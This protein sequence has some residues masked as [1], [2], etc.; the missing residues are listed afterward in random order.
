M[1]EDIAELEQ[2]QRELSEKLDRK[3]AELEAARQRIIEENKQEL[4][5]L[6]YDAEQQIKKHEEAVL[7]EYSA[8]LER[9]ISEETEILCQEF[10]KY[11][12][13]YEEVCTQVNAAYDKEQK[14]TEELLRRQQNF[15]AAY[16]KHIEYAKKNAES[17]KKKV[18]EAI[19]NTLK[20]V[21]IEW[22]LSGHIA[23]YLSRVQ[24]IDKW[25]DMGF[26]ESAIGVGNNVLLMLELDILEV[27]E[28]FRK[29]FHYYLIL[30]SVLENARATIFEKATIVPAEFKRFIK[31]EKIVDNRMSLE[32]IE[33]W[34]E[35]RF[36]S[37]KSSY[38]KFSSEMNAFKING[39]NMDDEKSIKQYM[40]K[41]PE[42]SA[43]FK[44]IWLYN[45]GVQA[46][47]KVRE[48]EQIISQMFDRIACFEERIAIGADI[49]RHFEA[50]GE[51]K[52]CYGKMFDNQTD[53]LY[54][55]YIECMGGFEFE[56]II[57]PV[58]R[59]SDNKWINNVRC[60]MG[61][62]INSERHEDII[63]YIAEALS[64]YKI[65]ISSI[66]RIKPE[67]NSS[68]R[69]KIANADA[70]LMINGRLN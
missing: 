36:S 54:N 12:R 41:H 18:V 25:I 24:E 62:N 49:T 53:P 42:R 59:K 66:E 70:C 39:I 67:Q 29:W 56:V 30:H 26:Y 31:G 16:F 19:N 11:R 50:G 22:F 9:T 17:V 46:I 5:K 20:N 57:V 32:K 64:N 23:L 33:Y 35:G 44:E 37:L 4:E 69:I 15:E 28:R 27:N 51:Y 38:E 1:H 3:T 55:K 14:R 65:S 40:I 21:P 2:R 34:S 8:V 68:E 58:L 45:R 7:E 10:E 61:K 48:A 47:S 6:K 63:S 60:F 43:D 13:Q 52:R